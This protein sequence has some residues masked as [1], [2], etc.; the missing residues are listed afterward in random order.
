MD[1]II[2]EFV[3]SRCNL[4]LKYSKTC[5]KQPLSKGM[6]IGFQ[7]Q[8]ISLNAGQNIAKCSKRA[9]CNTFDLH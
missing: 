9:F 3:K 4:G 7:D 6:K 2:S 8:L 5:V 1:I